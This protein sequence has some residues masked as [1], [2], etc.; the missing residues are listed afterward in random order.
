[1]AFNS[2][3]YLAYQ[4][5]RLCESFEPE[6]KNMSQ[7]LDV[8]ASHAKLVR[9]IQIHPSISSMWVAISTKY[10]THIFSQSKL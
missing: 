1:M 10:W 6:K 8:L 5:I 4:N 7:Q 9:S 3:R 2:M